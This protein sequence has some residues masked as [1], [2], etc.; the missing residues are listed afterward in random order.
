M[1]ESDKISPRIF[2]KKLH[3][4]LSS[5][6][7]LLFLVTTST[8]LLLKFKIYHGSFMNGWWTVCDGFG[9]SSIVS[10]SGPL[11]A[12]RILSVAA[13][14]S[15]FVALISAWRLLTRLIGRE[16]TENLICSLAHFGAGLFLLSA[17]LI[18]FC[19]L[20]VKVDIYNNKMR[21]YYGFYIGCF[22]CFLSFFLGTISLLYHKGLIKEKE[23]GISDIN[24][25]AQKEM[26]QTDTDQPTV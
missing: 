26:A 4:I 16:I 10:S 6:N 12:A 11:M 3:N 7:F 17:L 5:V 19:N 1:I 13:V 9:C 24:A 15:S 8:P 23:N 21:T 14:F 25:G 22:V 20:R 2:P 18:T